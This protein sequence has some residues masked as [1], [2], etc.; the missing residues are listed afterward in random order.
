MG[1]GLAL[2]AMAAPGCEGDSTESNADDITDV[3]NSSVKNQSIG[4]CWVYASVGWAESLHLTQTGKQLNISESWISYWHWYEQI[5]G[6]PNGKTQLAKL[7]KDQIS[8][9]GWFGL[10]AELMRRY[11]VMD[12]GA[13][14]PE[15]GESARSS[16]QSSALAAIN[17]SLKSGALSD[18]AARRDR[19]LV[20]AELDRAWGLT[21]SVSTTLDQTFGAD[22]SKT[23][24][25]SGNSPAADS[26]IRLASSIEVGKKISLSDAIGEPSSSYD[27]LKRK[28]KYAW[29]EVSFPKN[30]SSQRDYFRR[31][32]QSMH[33]GMPV[34]MVWFVDF[35]AMDS[36]NRFMAPPEKPGHQGGHMT[37]VEDYQASNVPGFGTLEAGTLVTDPKALDA[38]LADE[39]TIDFVRIKNSWGSSLA[40]PNAS[41]DLRG[42]YD[43]YMPYFQGPLTRCTESNGD[44]CGIKASVT[45][46]TSLV[47]P[48][49]AF[50]TDAKAV[51]GACTDICV[52]GPARAPTCDE[53]TDLICSQDTWC[54]ESGW[55]DACVKEA[56]DICELSCN[57]N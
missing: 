35:A 4:N 28:G 52:E 22:V 39:A 12:E 56:V 51:E 5:A 45:G 44:A 33:A 32:Q 40:P 2:T 25:D 16:R 14:I 11:G 7:D 41:S 36:Q 10:A 6:G 54:C 43:I 23:F 31:M 46:L 38:A 17:T 9:G 19:K 29:N 24:M 26:G 20:R 1:L 30:T 49:D 27:F 53:C 47:L 21:P 8:T 55:D 57:S 13:F 48:P 50:V 42:Y 15:E 37:V 34:I 3:K 18:P